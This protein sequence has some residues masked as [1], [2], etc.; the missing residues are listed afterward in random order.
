MHLARAQRWKSWIKFELLDL[1]KIVQFDLDNT[2]TTTGTVIFKQI[3]GAPIGGF[4]SSN[5]ANIY[6]IKCA[7]DENNFHNNLKTKGLGTIFYKAIRQIDDLIAWK[8]TQPQKR[9]L[10]LP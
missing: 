7:Y 10:C 9:R 1:V 6:N 2:Y 8:T 5:Y 3:Q 4:P